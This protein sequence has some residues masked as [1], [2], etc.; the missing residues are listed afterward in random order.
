M[1]TL[2]VSFQQTWFCGAPTLTDAQALAQAQVWASNFGPGFSTSLLTVQS[3]ATLFRRSGTLYVQAPDNVTEETFFFLKPNWSH[4]CITVTDIQQVPGPP[5]PAAEQATVDQAAD[6]N[7]WLWKVEDG[8]KKAANQ[9]EG[10]LGK[11]F[12][13]ALWLV[14]A[15]LVVWLVLETKAWQYLPRPKFLKG[16]A[17]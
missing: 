2:K 8:A 1:I 14:G 5:D 11:V 9:A 3:D 13:D 12:T 6:Q 17:K 10:L 15:V 16:R 4:D 7:S